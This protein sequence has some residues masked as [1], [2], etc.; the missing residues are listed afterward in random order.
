MLLRSTGPTLQTC[1]RRLRPLECALGLGEVRLRYRCS[2]LSHLI[3][4]CFCGSGHAGTDAEEMQWTTLKQQAR[5]VL[6]GGVACLAIALLSSCQAETALFVQVSPDG[7]LS[8]EVDV[9]LRDESAKT[10]LESIESA[11]HALATSLGVPEAGVVVSGDEKELHLKATLLETSGTEAFGVSGVAA[12]REGENLLLH[13]SFVEPKVLLEALQSAVA[14]QPDAVSVLDVM[15]RSFTVTLRLKFP[16]KVLSVQG[17]ETAVAKGNTLTVSHTLN[18]W[19]IGAIDVK[20]LAK[21]SSWYEGPLAR[22][23]GVAAAVFLA[24]LVDRRRRSRVSSGR[25]S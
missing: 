18:E 19:P 25:T 24:V 13:A 17:D 5:A 15:L 21:G 22:Y 6:H 20:A 4:C 8:Q 12:T 16:G 10:T 9:M 2:L 14:D 7:A 3:L 1:A 23:M 11:R